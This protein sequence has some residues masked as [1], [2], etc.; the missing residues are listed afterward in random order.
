MPRVSVV[1]PIFNGARYLQEALDSV[2][3][4][5][6]RDF[7]VVCV[8]DGSS[9]DSCDIVTRHGANP[10]LLRQANAGGCAARNAGVR[11][12]NGPYIAFLDQD[13]VWYPRKL[14][15]QVAALDAHPNAALALCNSDRMDE[16]GRVVQRGATVAERPGLRT[17]PLG[18]LIGEDQLLSSAV[19]VRREPF[20]RAGMFD[21][22]LHG[23]EDFDLAARL[24]REGA[25]IFI[26][27]SGMCY[28]INASG[29][30]QSG[31]LRVIRSRERFLLK[32]KDLYAGEATKQG[33]IRQMLA[34]CYSDWGWAEV[35]A[36][37]GP[38]GRE[39]LRRSLGQSPFKLRTYSRW[40]R[41]YF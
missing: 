18:R 32:M 3:A 27:D 37:H 15:Q 10:T 7:E 31:G 35:R 39:K 4:Q 20:V 12:S 36:G 41:S 1:I 2:A 30:S 5:T 14:E 38:S 16:Q 34:E 29:Q 8:D 17:E 40:L 6:F 11:Q 26:E 25:F 22:H 23:F 13:D 21:E 24:R 33:L 19:M 28:R 9:D